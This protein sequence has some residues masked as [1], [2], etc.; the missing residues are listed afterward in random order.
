M[1]NDRKKRQDDERYAKEQKITLAK[2]QEKA[3]ALNKLKKESLIIS[4]VFQESDIQ[5]KELE[6]GQNNIENA[7]KELIDMRDQRKKKRNSKKQGN[8]KN[9]I[10]QQFNELYSKIQAETYELNSKYN[11]LKLFIQQNNDENISKHKEIRGTQNQNEATQKEYIQVIHGIQNMKD[12]LKQRNKIVKR[13]LLSNKDH[14]NVTEQ[15]R[16]RKKERKKI[17]NQK[18]EKYFKFYKG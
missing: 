3:Q 5:S 17:D 14:D 15:Q 2:K 4:I 7:I 18:I 12:I 6:K 11:K 16:N 13:I 10:N 9:K 1:L 8:Q